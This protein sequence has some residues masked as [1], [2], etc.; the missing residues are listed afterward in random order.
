ML[1]VGGHAI[2]H[3]NEW[4]FN[5]VFVG[6]AFDPKDI[7]RVNKTKGHIKAHNSAQLITLKQL[8]LMQ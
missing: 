4:L 8:N 3:Y 2:N 7:T 1:N 6:E 5:L